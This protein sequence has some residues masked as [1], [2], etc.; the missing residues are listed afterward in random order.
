METFEPVQHSVFSTSFPLER[1]VQC[2]VGGL[3]QSKRRARSN[4]EAHLR[5]IEKLT[6]SVFCLS[7]LFTAWRK[8]EKKRLA[9]LPPF[10]KGPIRNSQRKETPFE[11]QHLYSPISAKM[12]E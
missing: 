3:L 6:V 5:G 8:K 1:C 9:H 2:D 7:A 11:D 4:L 10:R 12:M